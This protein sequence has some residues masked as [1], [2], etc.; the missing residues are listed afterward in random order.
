MAHKE[1]KMLP[2]LTVNNF[3]G[4]IASSYELINLISPNTIPIAIRIG[5]IVS[6]LLPHEAVTGF[7]IG[8]GT[9]ICT[10]QLLNKLDEIK[11][12][13]IDNSLDMLEV[14]RKK[15][16]NEIKKGRLTIE[17]TDA[18]DALKKTP[19]ESMDFIASNFTIHNFDKNY[20]IEILVEIF[21]VLKS[22]G[23][24][25]NGDRY[26]I[27]DPGEHLKETQKTVRKLFQIFQEINRLDLLEEWIVHLFSD[28]SPGKILYL[29]AALNEYKNLGFAD[30]IVDFR[31]GVDTLLYAYKPA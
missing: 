5:E 26:A 20:R 9:G 8:C 6:S 16:A 10:V 13:A 3:E 19:S 7:E 18:L 30:I 22:G 25:I 31:D 24:F 4:P 17:E 28:E 29:E 1:L 27:S 15:L 14:A 12:I 23:I 11:I 21:R 2:H